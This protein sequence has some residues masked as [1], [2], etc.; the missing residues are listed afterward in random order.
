METLFPRKD[1]IAA[2]AKIIF[3]RMGKETLEKRLD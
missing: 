2:M 3:P 1:Y